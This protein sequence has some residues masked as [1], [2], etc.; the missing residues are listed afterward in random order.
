MNI[1]VLGTGGVGQTIAAKLVDIGHSVM[2]GTRDVSAALARTQSE[3]FGMPFGVWY[4]SHQNIKLGTFSQAAAHG[5]V[6]IN[7]TSGHGTLPALEATGQANLN[8]K[9]LIDI[10]N[11]LDFS[12]GMPPFLFVASTD[13]LAEQIQARFPAAKV[14][15]TLNTVTAAVMV[16]PRA[17]GNGDHHMFVGG[18]DV[19]AKTAVTGYL[20]EWFGWQHVI[21]VGDITS[22][23]AM[24]MYVPLWLRLFAALETPMV[25]V[26]VVR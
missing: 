2:I 8:G 4:P 6:V 22:A 16:N 24:E 12:R 18:N 19:A 15:K 3:G 11:P 10:S 26:K 7:A 1:G 21:D 20:K 25:N 5:E 9:I 14:V 23:R 17:V 13:S